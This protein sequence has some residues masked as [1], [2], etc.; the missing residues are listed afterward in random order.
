MNNITTT[1]K[2]LKLLTLPFAIKAKYSYII[3]DYSCVVHLQCKI[4]GVGC[5]CYF[6]C[7]SQAYKSR[8][9]CILVKSRVPLLHFGRGR[10]RPKS[11]TPSVTFLCVF[12]LCVNGLFMTTV[13]IYR[14]WCRVSNCYCKIPL[15]IS[16]IFRMLMFQRLA[17]RCS[18]VTLYFSIVCYMFVFLL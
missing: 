11:A 4:L 14:T 13:C 16:T 15:C 10:D 8:W 9:K 12:F 2:L 3:A 1:K 7:T 18:E 17:I 5:R 6:F